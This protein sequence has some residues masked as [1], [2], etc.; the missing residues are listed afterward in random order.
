MNKKVKFVLAGSVGIHYVVDKIEKRSSDLNDLRTIDF[1]PL[2]NN[3]AHKYID[4]AT[5]GATGTYNL[6]LKE[7]LLCCQYTK[8]QMP[9]IT[10]ALKPVLL[11][12]SWNMKPLFLR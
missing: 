4:W 9:I 11:S 10:K 12:A 3:E 6:E 8:I 7:Y 1:K 5:K 2:S